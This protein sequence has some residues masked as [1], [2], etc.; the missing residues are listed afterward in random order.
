MI[1][2]SPVIKEL[3]L[4]RDCIS[5]I[6][7]FTGQHKDTLQQL[8]VSFGIEPDFFLDVMQQDQS[9][10]SLT[11]KLL[12]KIDRI[13]SQ[14][15]PDWIVAQGDTTSV[16]A[17]ALVGFYHKIKFAH[18]EAGLRTFNKYSPFPEEL[19]RFVSGYIADV[20]FAPT[21]K[22]VEHLISE[23]I[24]PEKI[25][26][27]GNTGIDA[28]INEAKKTIKLAF[29]IPQ[30]KKII[31]VTTHRREN[32]SKL[33]GIFSEILKIAKRY[34]DIHI[35]YPVHM[36]PMISSKAYAMFSDISNIELLPPLDYTHF[37]HLMKS[38]DLI[39]TDSGGVQEEAPTFGIPVL[40]IRDTTERPEGVQAGVAQLVKNEEI[41]D[42]FINFYENNF[43]R[44]NIP[45]PYGDGKASKRIVDFF[46][47]L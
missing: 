27:T 30:N 20:H 11:A 44:H 43:A 45:N 16:F 46:L 34:K 13:V 36:N 40:I 21:T 1:K 10:A 8:A 3:Q 38:C 37:I 22:A 7:V 29:K 35:F 39:L 41:L 26:L 24:D 19:N 9:L 18:I 6:V 5:T 28:L 12:M 2:M 4:K 31:L 33:D 14:E 47:S 15:K 42:Y 25:I 17:A 23:K 32:L